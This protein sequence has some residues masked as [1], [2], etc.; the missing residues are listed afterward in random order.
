M[1]PKIEKARQ[2]KIEMAAQAFAQGPGTSS[3]GGGVSNLIF[4]F[5]GGLKELKSKAFMQAAISHIKFMSLLIFSGPIFFRMQQW[6]WEK[7][8]TLKMN[9]SYGGTV[10]I[11]SDKVA[12][13]EVTGEGTQASIAG[14]PVTVPDEEAQTQGKACISFS[15]FSRML[16]L[17]SYMICQ[18]QP[19]KKNWET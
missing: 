8:Q 2:I 15:Q 6:S 10:L 16:P 17:F 12:L 9:E 7:G 5:F 4:C 11:K 19:T 1:L 3:S 18:C 13:P 14:G